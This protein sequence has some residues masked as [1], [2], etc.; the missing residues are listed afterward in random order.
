M[1]INILGQ[2]YEILKLKSDERMEKLQSNGLC[3]QY[4]KQILIYD[5]EETIE[6]FLNMKEFKDR[7]LRH[8]IIHAF[9]V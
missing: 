9:F 5:S 7:V 8:E 1:K 3:E 6:T 2:E 4:A